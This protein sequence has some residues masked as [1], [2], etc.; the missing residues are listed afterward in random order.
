VPK[1]PQPGC[2]NAPPI[3]AV[4]RD[5]GAEYAKA[6]AMGAPQAINVADRFH[7]VKNLTEALQ[8]LL[9]RWKAGNQGS[10]SNA[11]AMSGRAE[12]TGCF[13]RRMASSRTSPCGESALGST[14]RAIRTLSTG[15]G[16]ARRRNEAEARSRSGLGSRSEPYGV[17]WRLEPSQKRESDGRGRVLLRCLRRMS[18]RAGK[19]GR[20]TVWPCGGKSRNKATQEQGERSTAIWRRSNKPKGSASANPQRLAARFLPTL[21][22]GSDVA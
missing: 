14:S 7:V 2:S 10:Q 8:L 19:L 17:G 3:M 22:S 6:A 5:R 13:P 15:R 11:R 9:A 12:Q 16:V 20:E 4:S 21:P 18:F 1:P